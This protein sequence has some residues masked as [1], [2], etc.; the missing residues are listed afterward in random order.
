[1]GLCAAAAGAQTQTNI[2]IRVL[3]GDN[4]INSIRYHRGHD[5][6]VQVLNDSG[7]PLPHATVSFL[8]PATGASARFGNAGLSVTVETDEHGMAVGRGL[9][10]NTVEGPFRIRVTASWRGEAANAGI[11]QTNAEPAVKS[12]HGK[13][14]V[15]A[16]IAAGGAAAGGIAALHGGKASETAATGSTTPGATISPGTPSFGPPH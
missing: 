11:A 16:A 10:P 5:P 7:E 1:L 8:L 6:A 12:S 14:I 15:I 4:A 9:V 2:A 13:W 3:E